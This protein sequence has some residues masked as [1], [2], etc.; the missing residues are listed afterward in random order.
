M[1][2]RDEEILGL[3]MGPR[4]SVPEKE[5]KTYEMAARFV[6]D[7]GNPT[8]ELNLPDKAAAMHA[9]N[10]QANEL[11]RGE[12]G[13]RTRE[14]S[15]DVNNDPLFQQY[16]AQAVRGG[17][18]A[19]TD[20]MA[21]VAAQTG[22]IAGSYAVSAGAGAYNDYMQGVNDVIPELEQLAYAKYQDDLNRD[23]N[24]YKMDE[25]KRLED[26]EYNAMMHGFQNYGGPLTDEQKALI[27]A[28]G[29]YITPEGDV[30]DANGNVIKRGTGY[31]TEIA[32]AKLEEAQ[33]RNED[34]FA[35]YLAGADLGADARYLEE[36]G[37]TYANGVLYDFDG[38]PI[39]QVW[40]TPEKKDK[41][42]L[43][44]AISALSYSIN[45][46]KSLSDKYKGILNSYGFR[47]DGKNWVNADGVNALNYFET[48]GTSGTVG[49]EIPVK[50]G[51]DVLDEP[52]GEE[53]KKPSEVIPE[54]K[55][56]K[57]TPTDVVEGTVQS[58]LVAGDTKGARTYLENKFNNGEI[59]KKQLDDIVN[60]HFYQFVM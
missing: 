52:E 7:N 1:N 12:E 25:A 30:V 57:Y 9:K 28:N 20:T 58:Y 19:M 51:D 44:E 34:L 37:Y 47:Y 23:Y 53:P 38:K 26:A 54:N 42:D 33:K 14:F 18:K 24:I 3:G 13:Y 50:P 49:N 32:T 15:Y 45:N 5:D 39:E 27:Y 55:A 60:K 8:K 16:K 2:K 31:D 10:R 56:G 40:K 11:K 35:A 46:K 22:G 29:G 36:L 43:T 6:D 48:E 59:S 4:I 41:S 17:Q 21:K